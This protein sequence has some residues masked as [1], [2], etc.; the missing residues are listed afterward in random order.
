MSIATMSEQK[1]TI[2]LLYFASVREATSKSEEQIQIPANTTCAQLL[3]RLSTSYPSLLSMMADL[4]TAV[5]EKYVDT[6]TV[7]KDRDT[8]AVMPPISGG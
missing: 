8:V 6:N 1:I 2:R 7:L 4:S 3:V 5:N